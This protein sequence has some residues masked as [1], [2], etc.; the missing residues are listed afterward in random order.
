MVFAKKLTV[1]QA[2]FLRRLENGACSHAYIIEG[3]K[4]SGKRELAT[5]FAKTLLCTSPQK[6]CGTCLSCRR[7]Q[8]GHHP[9]VHWYGDGEKAVPIGD[10]RDLIKETGWIP[11]EG[12]RS[13]FVINAA[14]KMRPEA[15]NALL[16][17]FEEPP[18]GV[19]IFLLANSG[20]ELLPTIR[21]RGQTV[22]ISPP[23][24]EETLSR[25]QAKFPGATKQE[26]S[27][28]VRISG[29]SP[30][31]AEAF[32]QKNAVQHREGAKE[33]LDAAFGTDKYR[34]LGLVSA[35]KLKRET[36]LPL[37]DSFLQLA[38]DLLLEK[39]GV[40]P[41]LFSDADGEKYGNR[42]SKR[43]LAQMCDLALTCR[44]S[45]ES[46]GNVTAVMTAFA[47]GLWQAA[48]G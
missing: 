31:E 11:T 34:L 39:N 7:V 46:Y 10:I 37:V 32:L 43:V 1:E 22:R 21:S 3:P 30:G 13:V 28:A 16:K 20:R 12:D 26:L 48:N 19:V 44:E 40:E 14:E 9:D 42:A 24:P 6:P 23:P 15:Q 8:D 35:S 2:D 38:F 27:A 18:A 5:W 17:V 33:W 47:T 29:G 36:A 41:I 25:L 45:L 4:G